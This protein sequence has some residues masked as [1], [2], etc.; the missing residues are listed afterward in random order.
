MY[1]D[2]V[3]DFCAFLC[4]R[5]H[6][7]EEILAHLA[8]T[9]YKEMDCKSIFLAESA[10]DESITIT[11]AFGFTEDFFH[12][13]PNPVRMSD[14]IPLVDAM[15]TRS[16]VWI[17]SLPDWGEDYPQLTQL[18]YPYYSKTFICWPIELSGAPC[19]GI[20]VFCDADLTPNAELDTFFK[21]TANLL[22]LYL[23]SPKVLGQK[24]SPR[25][26][27][28]LESAGKE[29]SERQLLILKLMSEGKTNNSI[30]EMLG[31]SESTIRQ[32]TIKIYSKLGCEG[33][34]EA[35]KIYRDVL[36][37]S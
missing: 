12:K 26:V 22:A 31:Y 6:S 16:T 20:G 35:S 17:T 4:E 13:H 2:L 34:Q 29:L 23:F 21:A 27:I 19:G 33:R 24:K 32:E 30:S 7:N 36:S 18:N 37:R 1:L 8:G 5:E 28:D 9:I 25:Q 11:T 15:K 14:K 3:S 10:P